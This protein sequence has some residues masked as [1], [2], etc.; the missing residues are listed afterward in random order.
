MDSEEVRYAHEVDRWAAMIE[1]SHLMGLGRQLA[2][3]S[4]VKIDG[5]R[6]ELIVRQEFAHLL[7]ENS[8]QELTAVVAQL[9]P[10]SEFIINKSAITTTAPADIQQNINLNR[11]QRAEDS[12]H[13]DPV[14][15]TLVNEFGAKLIENSIKPL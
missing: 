11:Q 6:I 14:I 2:L 4:E 10:A 13:Q 12:I 7:N 9:A 15:N 3:N 8:E 5:S 1:Q